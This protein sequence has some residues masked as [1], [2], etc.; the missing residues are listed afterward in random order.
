[1]YIHQVGQKTC[2]NGLIVEI[3]NSTESL[4]PVLQT[5]TS[6]FR[7]NISEDNQNSLFTRP[8]FDITFR[9]G[10]AHAFLQTVYILL[11]TFHWL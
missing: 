8:V 7:L 11:S 6:P 2:Y 4:A 10:Q 9:H 5:D 1:M 3:L